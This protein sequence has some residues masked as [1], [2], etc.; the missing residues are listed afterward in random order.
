MSKKW[1]LLLTVLLMLS[2]CGNAGLPEG[3]SDNSAAK[4]ESGAAGNDEGQSKESPE[5]EEASGEES[6]SMELSGEAAPAEGSKVPEESEESFERKEGEASAEKESA[7]EEPEERTTPTPKSSPAPSAKPDASASGSAQSPKQTPPPAT[8]STPQASHTCSWDG[9]KTTQTATCSGEG[10]MT[11][12]CTSCGKT[13]TETIAKTD[14]SYA[15]MYSLDED[16]GNCMKRHRLVDICATCGYILNTHKD[17]TEESH[18]LN[19][20]VWGTGSTCVSAVTYTQTCKNCEKVCNTQTMGPTGHT[21]APGNSSVCRDCGE[22]LEHRYF[23]GV[24]TNCSAVHD[25]SWDG[26]VVMSAATCTSEGEIL[27]SCECGNQRREKIP[28]LPIPE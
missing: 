2:G 10:V 4:A 27:Y 23:K 11:Y 24:C 22:C 9:G 16:L 15:W 18:E 6:G 8:T 28:M 3:A 1:I 12:T 17:T 20:P 13:R 26:G 25:C 19:E 5:T 14:H 21:S 7:S